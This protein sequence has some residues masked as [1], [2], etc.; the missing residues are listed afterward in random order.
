MTKHLFA[1]SLTLLLLVFLWLSVG[2]W[3]FVVSLTKILCQ[4]ARLTTNLCF[5]V[6]TANSGK[7]SCEDEQAGIKF[8]VG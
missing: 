1:E 3:D 6:V 8:Q 2:K 5:L 4:K 7:K